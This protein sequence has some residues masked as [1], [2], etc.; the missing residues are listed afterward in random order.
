MLGHRCILSGISV[1][2]YSDSGVQAAAMI[3]WKVKIVSLLASARLI[4]QLPAWWV[5]I[6]KGSRDHFTRFSA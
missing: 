4:A 1:R 2:G 5:L 3:I 6:A